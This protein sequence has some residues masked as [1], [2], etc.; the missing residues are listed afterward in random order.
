MSEANGIR[1]RSGRRA[2]VP[3]PFLIALLLAATPALEAQVARAP[4]AVTPLRASIIGTP[5]PVAADHWVYDVLDRLGAAGLLDGPAADGGRPLSAGVIASALAYA[6][7]VAEGGALAAFAEEAWDR[8]RAEFP[9]VEPGRDGASSRALRFRYLDR[10]EPAEPGEVWQGV[11]LDG[12]FSWSP[13]GPVS[14]LYEPRILTGGPRD[15]IVVE[16]GRAVAAARWRGLWAFVGRERPGFT[17]GRSGG[18]VLGGRAPLDGFGIGTEAPVSLPVLG[19]VRGTAFF[20]RF[21]GDG[22][23]DQAYFGAMRVSFA[24]AD[25]VEVHLNRSL[26]YATEVRGQRPGVRDVLYTLVGKHTL[27]EDQRASIGLRLRGRVVGLPVQ[28][29]VEWGFEDTAGLD[30]D[31][32]VVAGVYVPA[33]RGAPALAVRYEFVGFGA[34]A[35]PYHVQ[36]KPRSWYRHWAVRRRYTNDGGILLGH[37]L[38]GYGSEHRVEVDGW[39]TGRGLHFRTVLYR[40]ERLEGNLLHD[41]FPGRSIGGGLDARLR[42]HARFALEGRLRQENGDAGWRER[43]VWFGVWASF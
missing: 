19:A 43:T 40:R 32:G 42:L 12:R 6:A 27:F 20:S 16:H 24:P 4:V 10:S 22:L 39:L 33:V 5:T 41:V 37:P 1:E 18:V 36:P 2:T 13:A 23:A 38:G 34:D 9:D 11:V 17:T 14:F 26:L 21:E 15:E 8:F 28:T 3:A 7:S 25:W 31:P 35:M 29:Y 30:D